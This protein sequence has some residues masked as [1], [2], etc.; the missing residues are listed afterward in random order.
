MSLALAEW[1]NSPKP[2]SVIFPF[3]GKKH[4][5]QDQPDPAELQKQTRTRKLS[6]RTTP[7]VNRNEVFFVRRKVKL[8]PLHRKEGA[9][10][11][12]TMKEGRA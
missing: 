3:F 5:N 2:H 4:R 11:S 9:E 8:R 7:N 12:Q 10:N 6:L 1:Q